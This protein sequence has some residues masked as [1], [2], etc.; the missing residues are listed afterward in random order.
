ML[1]TLRR[2]PLALFLALAF[3]LSWYPWLLALS[4]GSSSGPNPLGPFVAAL[5]ASAIVYGRGGVKE[6]LAKIVRWRAGV[7]AYLF[8]IVT[9]LLLCAFA[10]L[11]TYGFG[12]GAMRVQPLVWTDVIERFVFIFLFIGLGEEPG[13]RGFALP[14]LQKGHSPMHA[15]LIL[16]AVWA[17]WHL[18]LL[19]SEF[20][21]QVVP[22]FLVSLLGAAL[23]QTW[24]FNRSRHSVL[25]QMILHATVNTVGSGIVFRWFTG[26]DLLILWWAYAL[27]W[28]AAGAALLRAS[29]RT[30]LA[31]QPLIA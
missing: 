18:P 31:Q 29:Q 11:V 22:P 12:R 25:V 14:E 23:F 27:L 10:V 9:P 24:L 19:G 26:G 7:D 15:T 20:P 6:L 21:L 16:A 30:T 17:V 2:H 5:I 13:W 4:R 8:A 3:P 1:D 28:L